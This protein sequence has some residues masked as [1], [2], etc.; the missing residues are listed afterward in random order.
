MA[1]T[2]AVAHSKEGELQFTFKRINFCA[3]SLTSLKV[4][5]L[6][7]FKGVDK[8]MFLISWLTYS[9]CSSHTCIWRHHQLLGDTGSL[10]NMIHN[11]TFFIFVVL[12]LWC[13]GLCICQIV[14][15]ERKWIWCQISKA[16]RQLWK[17][18]M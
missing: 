2:E 16:T 1:S 5:Y 18:N 7:Q 12:T 4:F 8:L 13:A 17:S 11:E 3:F 6:L 14:C 15:N 10:G 9:M